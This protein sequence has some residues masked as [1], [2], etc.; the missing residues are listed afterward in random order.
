MV[1]TVSESSRVY[2]ASGAYAIGSDPR[3]LARVGQTKGRTP[4]TAAT[5]VRSISLDAAS[6]TRTW[7]LGQMKPGLKPAVPWSNFHPHPHE[8]PDFCAWAPSPSTRQAGRRSSQS[9]RG[10]GRR[11]PCT[12][13]TPWK[14]RASGAEGCVAPRGRRQTETPARGARLGSSQCEVNTGVE[15]KAQS[16]NDEIHHAL[17]FLHKILRLIVLGLK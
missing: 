15:R 2:Y 4:M 6:S 3:V 12:A 7:P 14:A 16:P 11:S 8:L 17:R 1:G 9:T 5:L 13:L 10:K